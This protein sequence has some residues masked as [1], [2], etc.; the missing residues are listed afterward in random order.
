MATDRLI[1][2]HAT[3]GRDSEDD[4]MEGKLSGEGA[5]YDE[6]ILDEEEEHAR[7]LNVGGSG[8]KS[9][10]PLGGHSG[11]KARGADHRG[12]DETRELIHKMEEGAEDSA[13][14]R[15]RNSS[16][17]DQR[18]LGTVQAQGKV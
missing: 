6:D 4:E 16:E 13:S 11:K 15:S 12:R 17:S 14:E 18:R 5:R 8:R 10:R 2:D 9:L 3:R 1:S 7:L